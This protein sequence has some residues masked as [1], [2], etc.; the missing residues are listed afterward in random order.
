M[1]I[2]DQLKKS[3]A[4]LRLLV[5]GV[6]AGMLLLLAGLWYHQIIASRTYVESLQTQSFRTVRVPAIRGKILDRNGTPLADN[7]PSYQINLYLNELR[8]LFQTRYQ[9]LRPQ[10][11]LTSARIAE[12]SEQARFEVVSQIVQQVGSVIG[13]P[14]QI[15]RERFSKHYEQSLALPLPI[16]TDMTLEQVARFAER[17]INAPGLELEML[18]TRR[19]PQKQTAAHILGFLRRDNT[20]NEDEDAYFNYR[21]PDYRGVVGIEA[22]FDDELRGRAGV[23]SILVNNLGYR[24]REFDWSA[25]DPGQNVRLTMDLQLQAATEKALR[26]LGPS[27]RGAAIV[28]DA[29]SGDFL[30][31]ASAPTFDPNL[32]IGG[33][34]TENWARLSDTNT[35]PMICRATR[36]IYAP[37]SIFKIVIGIA[38]LENGLNPEELFRND[39]YYMVGSRR[40]DDEAP[41]GNYA[42]RRAFLK[43]SNSYFIH[44]GLRIGLDPIAAIARQLHLG[45]RWDVPL[46]QESGGI[47]PTRDWIR[48]HRGGGWSPG[49]TANLCIG[50]GDLAVTPMQMAVMTSAIANGGKVYWPRLVERVEPQADQFLTPPTPTPTARVRDQLTLSPRTFEVL[51]DAMLAD[52]EE[53]EATAYP[54]F[55]PTGRPALPGVRIGGKTGTAQVQNE[56]GKLVDKNTWFVSFGQMEKR[57]YTVVVMIESGGSGGGTCA[58]I[59]RQIYQA[60]QQWERQ[61]ERSEFAEVIR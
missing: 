51:H 40:I 29:N 34:S 42:F 56:R 36:E 57:L 48:K 20:S 13:T 22:T 17:P 21:L 41:E 5:A 1:M 32:F 61:P 54:A 44:F 4:Q 24:Q 19:Y 43:S 60:I 59:A 9:Q 46:M 39:G 10:G 53:P 35:R 7:V 28:M 33:I 14:L 11:R 25:P 31:L 8:P 6:I 30:A 27:T 38:C 58:P 23:R 15:E 47:F 2:V 55:H 37:G 50:Q 45:E 12:V 3:D 49:D 52:I 26:S 18:A 16:V